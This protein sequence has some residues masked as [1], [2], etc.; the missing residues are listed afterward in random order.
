MT[1][2]LDVP[3]PLEAPSAPL[4]CLE[5]YASDTPKPP[6]V[7]SNHSLLGEPERPQVSGSRPQGILPETPAVRQGQGLP[8]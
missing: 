8:F 5:H 1:F 7:A 3:L 4:W 6:T 2:G